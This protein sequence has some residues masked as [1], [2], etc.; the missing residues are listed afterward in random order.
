[1]SA[2]R[3]LDTRLA[4]ARRPSTVQERLAYETDLLQTIRR[5]EA[6]G[7]TFD[8][9]LVRTCERNIPLL[10]PVPAPRAGHRLHR[11]PS[12]T[13]TSRRATRSGSWAWWRT[14]LRVAAN[15]QG[16]PL[17]TRPSRL[18]REEE[19]ARMQALLCAARLQL[20]DDE[21]WDAE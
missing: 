19:E 17:V 2:S 15:S 5:M 8:A 9:E 13:A 21:T 20:E 3:E 10:L 14:N 16:R 1:M 7:Y 6:Q 11:A 4:E 18:V 12:R